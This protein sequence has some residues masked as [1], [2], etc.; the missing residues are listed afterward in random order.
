MPVIKRKLNTLVPGANQ[1]ILHG[2]SQTDLNCKHP[3]LVV[4][5]ST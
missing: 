5:P 2:G 4:L 3:L 1:L